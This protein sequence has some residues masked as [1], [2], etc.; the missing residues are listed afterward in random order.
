MSIQHK[1]MS[2]IAGFILVITVLCLVLVASLRQ[3]EIREELDQQIAQQSREVLTALQLTDSQLTARVQSSIKLLLHRIKQ[4]GAVSSGSNTQVGQESVPDLLI[5]N[6]PQANQFQLVDDLTDIMGGTATLFSRTGD[7]F[8]RV[9]TNVQTENGRAT[10]TELAPAGAAAKAILQQ[11]PFYGAVDILGH[12]YVT[13]YEPL[14]DPSGNTIGIAYV[15]YKADL[16]QLNKLISSSRILSR[17]FI[18]LQDA[19]G[20]LRTHSDHYK[21]AEIEAILKQPEDWHL[22]QQNFAPWGYKVTLAYPDEELNALIRYSVLSIGAVILLI[23]A[24]LLTIYWLLKQVVVSRVQATIQALTAITQGEGDLTRRFST[25]SADEFGAMAKSFDTLLDQLHQMVEQ[26]GGQSNQMAASA[27]Q[28]TTISTHSEQ[29]MAQLHQQIAD[30]SSTTGQLYDLSAQVSANTDQA[31]QSSLQVSQVMAQSRQSLRQ[32]EQSTQQQYQ[33]MEQTEQA[34]SQLVNASNQIGSV[35]DVISNIAEQTNLLALNAAIEAARAG[36][37]G[38]GFS[39]VADEVRSLAARTQSSTVEIKGMI[40]QLQQGVHQVHSLN[41]HY[42]QGLQ[43]STEQLNNACSALGQAMQSAEEIATLNTGI[44]ELASQQNGIAST[45]ERQAE[46]MLHLVQN[47]KQNVSSTQQAS[48]AVSQ[49]AAE[50]KAILGRY[51]I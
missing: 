21:N 7:R 17:G 16:D 28:L 22:V 11:Q 13:A 10:G 43:A 14:N 38:R 35:L 51:R 47:H 26:L 40:E 18:A 1:F 50:L 33:D 24:V 2:I 46:Q 36:D 9:S 49:L 31:R 6:Q 15:G 41:N 27:L 42:Q 3:Q 8:I 23:T 4:Q 20:Q 5:G 34:I 30:T 12:P 48:H 37:Q 25:Y 44:S 29:E 32:L 45:V 19:K 39:V